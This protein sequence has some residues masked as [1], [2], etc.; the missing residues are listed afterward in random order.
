MGSGIDW[1]AVNLHAG[2]GAV[3][4]TFATV[5]VQFAGDTSGLDIGFGP[6]LST[7]TTVPGLVFGIMFGALWWG[8]G[9]AALGSAVAYALAATV[10]YYCAVWLAIELERHTNALLPAGIAA[11]LLGAGLLTAAGAALLPWQRDVFPVVGSVVAGTALGALLGLGLADFWDGLAL[12]VP[13]QAGYAG[14]LATGLRRQA[15]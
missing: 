4:A 7:A 5:I 15:G 11:G 9:L 14:A 3:S 6:G 12:L 2:L 10:A 13:W 8:R 1:H